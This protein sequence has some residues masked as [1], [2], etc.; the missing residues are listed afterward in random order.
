MSEPSSRGELFD[1]FGETYEAA[2]A[3]GVSV[4]G[5]SARFYAEERVAWLATLLARRGVRATRVL[6][7]GCGMGSVSPLLLT[8]PGTRDVVGVDV[9]EGL[10]ARARVEHGA[11]NVHFSTVAAHVADGTFDVAYTNGVFHHI[12]PAD[13]GTAVDVVH[14]SLKH[15]GIFAFWEN[16]P[17]NPG[18]RYVMRRIE[19]DR[20]A[21]TLSPPEA[22]SL[23]RDRGFEILGTTSRFFFP[24]ILGALRGLEPL[25]S[26]IP[27]GG[28]YQ[29]LCRKP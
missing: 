25:L 26:V 18:T 17:W 1:R 15:G 24:R 4:T 23:L 29:V 12:P 28:Q 27:L 10:L 7:Y 3:R 14:R 20:D 5:E 16:N 8:L 11:A 6:D 21:I 19:F 13:R 2:L 22:R 9:S